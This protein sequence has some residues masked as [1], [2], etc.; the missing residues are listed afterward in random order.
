MSLNLQL[1]ISQKNLEKLIYC[2]HLESNW[3]KEQDAWSSVLKDPRILICFISHG[4]RTLVCVPY[5]VPVPHSIFGNIL[6]FVAGINLV[7]VF[8]FPPCFRCFLFLD[9]C[10]TVAGIA[11]IRVWMTFAYYDRD[12]MLL[13]GGFSSCFASDSLACNW[14]DLI[15]YCSL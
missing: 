5:C 15:L 7:T 8:T 13:L 1:E 11:M 10:Y 3:W 4:Y 14:W 6:L 2:R 12:R 9:I